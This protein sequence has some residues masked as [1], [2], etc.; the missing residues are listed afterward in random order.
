MNAFMSRWE[1]EE[2]EERRREEEALLR[3]EEQRNE[4]P[5]KMMPTFRGDYFGKI[6]QYPIIVEAWKKIESAG[7]RLRRYHAEFDEKE[8]KVI[9]FWYNRFYRWYLVTGAPDHITMKL[10]TL[11]LLRRA[12]AFFASV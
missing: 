7:S 10:N 5:V 4:E 3:E 2:A 12:V 6:C 9:R 1:R 8:R 11:D